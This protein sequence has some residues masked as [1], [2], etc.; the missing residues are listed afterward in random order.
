M[1]NNKYSTRLIVPANNF[2]ATFLKLRYIAL[3]AILDENNIIYD[4]FTIVQASDMKQK[5]EELKIK[6]YENTIVSIYIVNFYS[7]TMISLIKKAINYY[8]MKLSNKKKKK[9]KWCLD[10]IQFGMRSTLLNFQDC[11]FEYKGN[12]YKDN[13]GLAIGGYESAFLAD[14]VASFIFEKTEHLLNDTRY[15]EIYRDD[16]L[17]IFKNT[18]KYSKIVK[19]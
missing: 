19:F 2:T 5:V 9:I 7:S 18:L 10:L 11:F 12:G 14:L 4:K 16:G 8:T 17:I 15:K 1:V 13:I 6:K 3:K